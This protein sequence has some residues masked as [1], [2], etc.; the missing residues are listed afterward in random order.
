MFSHR[1]YDATPDPATLGR[2]TAHTEDPSPCWVRIHSSGVPVP[3]GGSYTIPGTAGTTLVGACTRMTYLYVLSTT[4]GGAALITH[5]R[6]NP[7]REM[8]VPAA[9]ETLAPVTVGDQE[10]AFTRGIYIDGAYVV[11]LGSGAE[12]EIYLARKSWGKIGA[13]KPSDPTSWDLS[14]QIDAIDWGYRTD[15]GW[16]PDPAPAPPLRVST[17]G[18]V[19]VSRTGRILYYAVVEAEGAQR[20]GRIWS[21]TDT[22]PVWLD[23]GI[24]ADLGTAGSSYL[25][26]TLQLQSQLHGDGIPYVTT[27]LESGGLNVVWSTAAV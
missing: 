25:G 5:L 11:L 2:Y 9:Q 15:T 12:G 13:W 8:L 6:W 16:S 19:S 17:A 20:T 18:P 21:S 27:V 26:G 14:A 1:W 7:G 22:S 4:V 10:I 23:T 24:T 3:I